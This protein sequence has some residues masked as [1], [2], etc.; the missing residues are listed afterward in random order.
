MHRPAVRR[1]YSLRPDGDAWSSPFP[2]LLKLTA[3]TSQSS[4]LARRRKY[5]GHQK[6]R[7]YIS[8]VQRCKAV[9]LSP[10][11]IGHTLNRSF[12]HRS[13]IWKAQPGNGLRG[14]AGLCSDYEERIGP[15]HVHHTFIAHSGI[16]TTEFRLQ[17][18]SL[19]AEKRR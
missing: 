17:R 8:G 3:R 7:S 13:E 14:C 4:Y 15:G 12:Q 9:P 2:I 18:L 5:S 10:S 19:R 16:H 6:P 1:L 11:G